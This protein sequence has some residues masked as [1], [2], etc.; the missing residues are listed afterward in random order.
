MK[1]F[2]IFS[3]WQSDTDA[4]INNYFIRDSIKTSIKAIKTEVE[5]DITLDR[6]T[7]NTTGSPQIIDTIFRKISSSDIF[8]C[9]LTIINNNWQSRFYK[10]KKTPNPNVLIEL[11]YAIKVLG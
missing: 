4:K 2:K 10:S 11:G 7:K 1:K 9:D 5:L 6:D 3:S 8:I